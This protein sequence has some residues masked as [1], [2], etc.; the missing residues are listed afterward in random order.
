MTDSS[1]ACTSLS[2]RLRVLVVDDQPANVQALYQALN[3]DYQVLV[4][5]NGEQALALCESK[6]PD[7][8]L[9]DVVMP[10]IDG[11]EVCERLKAGSNTQHIPVIFVTSHDEEAAETR[12]L[13][14]GAA[15]FI[16]K[17]I[18]PAVVRARVKTQL[19]LKCQSDL[20]GSWCSSTD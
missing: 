7:L 10:G 8:V 16:T 3:A 19:T 20:C 17:P 6:P 2:P 14:I 1:P 15:D 12:G 4:A 9:L 18:N 11:Y 5:T 13:G